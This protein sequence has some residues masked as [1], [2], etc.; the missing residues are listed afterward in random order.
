MLLSVL[1]WYYCTTESS[2]KLVSIPFQGGFTVTT[3]QL[4]FFL[5]DNLQLICLASNRRWF[6]AVSR[7]NQLVYI[8]QNWISSVAHMI[9]YHFQLITGDVA[10]WWLL[11][12]FFQS[13]KQNMY[14]YRVMHWFLLSNSLIRFVMCAMNA[15]DASI[16]LCSD[17]FSTRSSPLIQFQ[18]N[19]FIYEPVMSMHKVNKTQC[20]LILHIWTSA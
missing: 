18:E 20:M 15:Y 13:K 8:H 6:A 19:L 12:H 2:C 10:H 9:S 3:V 16:L 14:C 7:V 11:Y 17:F 1:T 5:W 4:T